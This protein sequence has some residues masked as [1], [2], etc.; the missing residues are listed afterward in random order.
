[1]TIRLIADIEVFAKI[2]YGESFENQT[3]N[4]S[5]LTA[6]ASHILQIENLKPKTKYYY[7]VYLNDK[8][9]EGDTSNYFITSP[10]A[11]GIEKVS[12]V[13]FGDC[14]TLQTAQVKVA[15]S[16]KSYFGS[17]P[18]D[19][20]LLLGDNA[21]N[22]GFDKE[23]QSNF[24]N[25][26][27]KYFLRNTVIWPAPGNHDYSDKVWPNDIGL[28]PDYYNIFS[29]PNLGECGGLASGTSAYYS[30]NYANIHF[31]SLD[32]YGV[33][34]SK[35]LYES[36]NSQTDWLEVDLKANSAMWTVVYFH[37]P[38]F[39]KGSHDSDKELDL[40]AIRENIVRILDKYKVDVV[41]SG[42]SHSYERSYL[43]H[44]YFGNELSFENE[45]YAS[46][47]SN[48]NY[49]GSINSCPYIKTDK[50]TIYVVAGSSGWVGSKSEGYPHNAMV[51]SNVENPGAFILEVESNKFT[52][53]FLTSNGVIFDE[54]TILK[55]V[56]QKI[57]KLIECG[58]EFSVKPSWDGKAFTELGIWNNNEFTIDSLNNNISFLI[59]DEYG[60]LA[61]TINV[62]VLDY[63]KPV[64]FSNSPILERQD[65][66]L[67]SKFEGNGN[68]TWLFKKDT[69]GV[70]ENL[71][72]NN[73]TIENAGEYILNA[74]Y[75]TCINS[76]TVSVEVLK[77]LEKEIEN[78]NIASVF[79]N[80]GS[81]VFTLDLEMFKG[82]E[83]YYLI[84]DINGHLLFKSKLI[85]FIEG[86][87]QVSVNLEGFA[88][89]NY[90]CILIGEDFKVVKKII[91]K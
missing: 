80:P 65:L 59:S 73:V 6:Q 32:S 67:T 1:M 26:Y 74:N 43:L 11:G 34:D 47:N 20:W 12:M 18:I 30:Y 21:Y 51:N 9:I 42:H 71:T 19:G 88:S 23:Y 56:N 29:V 58:E 28:K 33:N 55:N 15:E 41:L 68:L 84:S 22:Y 78:E 76:D 44:D 53:K 39:S 36:P 31:V 63:P 89:G 66:Q 14:G 2:K 37:H 49:N 64:A 48:A 81:D 77:I 3:L 83:Y 69:V 62:Q 72:L 8:L 60:C 45:K 25:V 90:F 4:L 57:D 52:G 70:A 17:K 7:S 35:K 50:G 38:P 86:K 16:V 24:F 46:S 5:S 13:A 54:F 61:D 40:I 79:P 27:Q 87:S 91:K 82:G 75:K 85:K 10:L